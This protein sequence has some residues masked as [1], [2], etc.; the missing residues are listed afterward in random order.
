M[1]D[2]DTAVIE[3]AELLGYIAVGVLHQQEIAL[4]I[5]QVQIV[6]I[7]S[8][9][10][11]V[12]YEDRTLIPVIGIFGGVKYQTFI[13]FAAS[14]EDVDSVDQRNLGIPDTLLENTRLTAGPDLAA[15]GA[16]GMIQCVGGFLIVGINMEYALL[17]KQHS[18]VVLAYGQNGNDAVFIEAAAV[19]FAA[20]DAV[21]MIIVL[22][23]K[24][25]VAQM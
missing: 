21:N 24:P 19:V 8:G 25:F 17:V 11:L 7:E 2:I 9:C 15:V 12:M 5:L 23:G 10:T 20:I 16:D 13:V 14:M 18:T 1:H 22:T 3:G 4:F 6:G